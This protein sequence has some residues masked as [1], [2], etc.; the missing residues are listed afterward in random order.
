MIFWLVVSN[1]TF[2]SISKKWNVIR[3]PLTKSIIFQDGEIAPPT[4]LK[5][6]HRLV[7]RLGLWNLAKPI[8]KVCGRFLYSWMGFKISLSV[9]NHGLVPVFV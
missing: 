4:S 6:V 7:T 5:M 2:I 9:E 3:N 8:G 1:M